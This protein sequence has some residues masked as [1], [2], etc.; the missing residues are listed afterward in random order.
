MTPTQ[1]KR[2]RPTKYTLK[3][4]DEI[5]RRLALGETLNQICRDGHMPARPTVI[6]WVLQDRD[7]FSDKYARAREQLY[8]HWADETVEISDD[9]ANDWMEREYGAGR[10]ERV[11]DN[12][13]VQR[14]RLR[15]DTRKWLLSKLL[16]KKYGDKIDLAHSGEVAV[17]KRVL[18][19]PED[20]V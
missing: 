16:P 8:E 2:G 15:V 4:A 14:S 13:C 5:C 7:G 20:E 3:V 6:D 9:S 18:G 1:P 11:V 17:V 10:K 19:V 12:E